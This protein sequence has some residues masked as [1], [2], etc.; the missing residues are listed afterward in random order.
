MTTAAMGTTPSPSLINQYGGPGFYLQDGNVFNA[1]FVDSAIDTLTTTAGG[2]RANALQITTQNARLSTVA[3][4]GDS[5]ILPP[6]MAGLEVVIA[7]HGVAPCQVF[8]GNSVSGGGV[9][10]RHL[11]AATPLVALRFLPEI[12]LEWVRGGSG[13]AHKHKPHRRKK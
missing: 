1:F 7:N 4:P 2:G 11:P 5:I 9:D 6:A 8:G 13:H 3:N 10:V 12:G